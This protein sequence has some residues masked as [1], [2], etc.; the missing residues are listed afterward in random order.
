[1]PGHEG[2]KQTGFEGLESPVGGVYVLGE[3][4]PA[5]LK[6]LPEVRALEHKDGQP[7]SPEYSD[8]EEFVNT[9]MPYYPEREINLSVVHQTAE[10]A[11]PIEESSDPSGAGTHTDPW[12][13]RIVVSDSAGTV[14]YHQDTRGHADI[15][16]EPWAPQPG[17]IVG[18]VRGVPHK[19]PSLIDGRTILTANE[20]HTDP[21]KIGGNTFRD[22]KGNPVRV[23]PEDIFTGDIPPGFE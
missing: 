12:E 8:L 17:Q 5:I 19:Q 3:M 2:E 1:M 7:L 18:F 10:D 15:S 9:V 22:E 20:A 13:L 4:N 6:G 23:N 21:Y 14:F 16:K 11:I